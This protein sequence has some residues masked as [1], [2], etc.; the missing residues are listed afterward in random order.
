[1]LGFSTIFEGK[2]IIVSNSSEILSRENFTIAHE[3][4]HVVYDFEDEFGAV[5]ID[6]EIIQSLF[7]LS[8]RG[9]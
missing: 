3:L 7:R 8:S 4:G 2:K 5:K 6:I 9:R 1:L